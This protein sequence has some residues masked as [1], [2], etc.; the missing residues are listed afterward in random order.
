MTHLKG[1]N[2]RNI[3]ITAFIMVTVLTGTASAADN[4]KD[5]LSQGTVRGEIKTL[6]FTR[7]FDKS[8]N[9]RHDNA[10]GGLLY[11]KTAPLK[12]I[13]FGV[14]FGTAKDINSDDDDTVY[15]ILKK[16]TDGSH[17]S[18]SRMQE[19]YIQGEYFNTVA[20][21]GAQEI[22]TPFMEPHDLRM[23]PRTYK[24]LSVI[25]NSVT[26]LT[27]SAYYITD[28]MGWS[29]EDF[30]SVSKAV[31]AE[32]GGAASID[33]DKAMVILG[34]S[35]NVP[36][37]AVKTNVQAWYYTMADVY[38]QTFFKATFSKDFDGFTLYAKPSVLWQK[39][40]GDDL[41]GDLDTHQY[42]ISGGVKTH[43]FD[44]TA[45]YAKTGDDGIVAPWGDEKAII[46]QVLAAGRAEEKA[47]ALRVSY[48]FGKLGVKG[49]S[50]YVFYTDYDVPA[51]TGSDMSEMDYSVQ[52]AFSGSLDGL[53]LRARYADIKIDDGEGY[54]D[55]RYYVTYKF[56]FGGKK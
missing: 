27:L 38:N 45:F 10:I 55:I 39:S 26:D 50:A 7:D 4:L 8:T 56:A 34:A 17:A 43:G 15:G 40:Q 47:K 35:Y 29:D 53:G 48:D 1:D 2:M 36:V 42:G 52:Y 20:K 16:D 5:M 37:E 18:F 6:D 22:R 41:N 19:Y 51:S 33:D 49:L 46:Q 30:V 11:Y 44:V 9:T 24:G 31:G 13:S 23:L 25:N 21:Y 32:P 28:S 12:G 54:N 14:A 3:L